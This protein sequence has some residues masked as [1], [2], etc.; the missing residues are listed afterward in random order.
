MQNLL[1]LDM[2]YNAVTDIT[3]IANLINLQT[4]SL[5]GCE[6]LKNIYPL[7]QCKQLEHIDIGH[8]GVSDIGVLCF[9]KYLS[10]LNIEDTQ[11]VDLHPLQFLFWL[12]NLFA[13]NSC[14]IDV[15]PLKD[16]IRLNFLSLKNNKIQDFSPIYH[17]QNYPSDENA[18][19][20]LYYVEDQ[21]EPTPQ[22]AHFYNKIT[23]VHNSQNSFRQIQQ[24]NKIQ[25]FKNSF[26]KTTKT[27]ISA[28]NNVLG[29]Y[30]K[31]AELLVQFIS[32]NTYNE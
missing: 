13:A 23:S 1:E 15:T 20:Q 30:N 4:I 7:K 24:E 31:Q 3:F 2:G 19:Y 11:V 21:T 14:V 22:E 26:T 18:D 9:H 27:V 16:L 8:S 25:K 10:I 5:E 28:L 6:Q 17:H 29:S 32:I 12:Q